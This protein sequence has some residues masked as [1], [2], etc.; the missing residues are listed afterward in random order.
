MK[1]LCKLGPET[2]LLCSQGAEGHTAFAKIPHAHRLN[3][4]ER[5]GYD[6]VNLPDH[7]KKWKIEPIRFCQEN[8]LDMLQASIVKYTVRFRDKN[9]VEDLMKAKRCLDMLVLFE[10][11]D[12]EWWLP[13]GTQ[14]QQ[15][16][17]VELM[18]NA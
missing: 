16:Q 14:Q 3:D 15:Q 17:A 13:A 11:G 7:Y 5:L 1:T 6:A 8:G 2:C 10:Q 4:S 9:G 12:P 18:T